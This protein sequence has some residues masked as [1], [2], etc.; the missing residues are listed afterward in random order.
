MKILITG[1]QGKLG[2]A[3]IKFKPS[4]TKIYPMDRIFLA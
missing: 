1:S 4:N 2:K 3:L